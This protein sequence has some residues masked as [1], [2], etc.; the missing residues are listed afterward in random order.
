MRLALKPFVQLR[1]KRH[2]DIM[3]TLVDVH[4]HLDS[5]VFNGR[6]DEVLAGARWAGVRCLLTASIHPRDWATV[7]ALATRYP[8]IVF[9]QGVHP[10]YCDDAAVAA[11]PKL[12]A[13]AQGAVAIGEIGLDTKSMPFPLERQMD[14]FV[15]QLQIAQQLDLPVNLHC[16]G[17][18]N[19]MLHLFKEYGAPPGG[20]LHNFSGSPELADQF[21]AHGLAFSLGGVLTWRNSAKR[22]RLL[23]HIF[24][25][26]LLLETDAPDIPPVEARGTPNTPANIL[27]N[28]HAA[29]ELLEETP[30]AVAAATTRNAQRIF[31]LDL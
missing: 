23:R 7:A 26:H 2:V 24:P 30:E 17:A 27:Y 28:L 14:V 13:A 21:M 20:I 8:E 29:A 9:A 16:R 5:D 19:E 31:G 12:A 4:C 22:N 25:D 3:L 15:P 6:L 18:F 10:W 11:L 1:D